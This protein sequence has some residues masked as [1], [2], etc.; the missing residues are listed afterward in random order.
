MPASS[1]VDGSVDGGD[2]GTDATGSDQSPW[3]EQL[4]KH[5]LE[6]IKP[7]TGLLSGLTHIAEHVAIAHK[8]PS[9]LS[10]YVNPQ[11]VAASL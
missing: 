5:R 8:P 6:G 2:E 9:W 4:Q 7:T 11:V 1:S 3:P 10:R